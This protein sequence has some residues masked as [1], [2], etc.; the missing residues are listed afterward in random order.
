MSGGVIAAVVITVVIAVAL[1][2]TVCVILYCK[3]KKLCVHKKGP[4]DAV[5]HTNSTPQQ[6]NMPALNYL[7]ICM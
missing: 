2:V 4:R 1:V 5:N 3:H 6:G 7:L